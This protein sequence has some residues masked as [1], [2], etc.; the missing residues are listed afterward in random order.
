MRRLAIVLLWGSGLPCYGQA[1]PKVE[2]EARYW[3]TTASGNA[4]IGAGALNT[5][6][7]LKKDLGTNNPQTGDFRFTVRP[8]NSRI[9]FGFEHFGL[10][11]DQPV[12]RTIEFNGNVYTV[13]TQVVTDARINHVVLSWSYALIHPAGRRFKLGPLVEGHRLWWNASLT[14]PALNLQGTD[15]RAIGYPAVGL[16]AE[17]VAHTRLVFFAEA[18]GLPAGSYGTFY[19]W[20]AGAR[21]SPARHLNLVGGF[22]VFDVN[23]KFAPD[24]ARVHFSGPFV[25]AAAGF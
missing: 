19:D 9:Q 11:G 7:D 20:E 12:D 13:G 6:L 24:Y 17:V 5:T 23:A 4:K 3:P 2:F 10:H 25:G 14:A 15:T 8:G 16:A 1:A 22:R 21:L 18:A